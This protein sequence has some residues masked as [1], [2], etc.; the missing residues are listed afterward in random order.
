[1]RIE[2]LAQDFD[3][4]LRWTVFPLHPETPL[5]GRKLTD[6]FAGRMDVPKVMADLKQRAEGMGLP[7]TSRTHTYNSRRAQELGKWAEVQ[8]VGD[9]FRETV[10]LAYFAEGRNIANIDELMAICKTLSLSVDD[11]MHILESGS[12]SAVVD[13]DW[14]R[15]KA[16]GVNS[17]P[18]HIYANRMLVGFQDYTA[19]QRLIMG[20]FSS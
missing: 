15:A 12:F 2:Q 17:V 5:G 8:G 4:Q 9:A 7:F 11:A 3:L 16:F 6:L 1:M 20:S 14:N 19:F 18:T 10:Y 13:A